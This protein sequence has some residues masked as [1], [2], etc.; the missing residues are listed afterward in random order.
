MSGGTFIALAAAEIVI[1]ENAV[2]G[3][4][5]PQVGGFPAASILSVV[6][7]KPEFTLLLGSSMHF[8]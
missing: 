5:D 8:Y 1:E 6:V 3:P 2:L 7:K 4:V